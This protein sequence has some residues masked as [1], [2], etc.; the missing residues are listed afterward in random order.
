MQSESRNS[1]FSF[2]LVWDFEHTSETSLD[3]I[4]DNVVVI[5]AVTFEDG[6]VQEKSLS[7][8][9]QGNWAEVATQ[10]MQN[11]IIH[12]EREPREQNPYGN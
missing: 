6:E 7:F 3:K 8:N 10:A 11:V 1:E 9:P 12:R 2:M 5:V 4:C